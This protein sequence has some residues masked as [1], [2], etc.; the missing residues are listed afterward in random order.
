L[1]GSL[2]VKL[3]PIP[4]LGAGVLVIDTNSDARDRQPRRMKQAQRNQLATP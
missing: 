3:S 2:S 4:A 1:F